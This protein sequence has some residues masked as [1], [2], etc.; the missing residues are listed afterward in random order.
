M[1]QVVFLSLFLGLVT[2][3]QT[4]ALRVDPAVKSVRIELGGREAGKLNGE[5]WT[6]KVDFGKELVPRELVA[7]GYDAK[8][9][10]IARASQLTNLS[11]PP[12]Q[13]DIVVHRPPEQ[14]IEVELVGRHRIHKR[15]DD[16]KLLLDG[17]EIKV[18]RTF[19]ARLPALESKHTHVLSAEVRFEDGLIARRD[20]VLEGE[21]SRSTG[22][23][24]SGVLVTLAGKEPASLEGCFSSNGAPLRASGIE[25]TD[26]LVIMVKDPESRDLLAR[27]LIDGNRPELR[28]DAETTER[29][30]WPVARPFN[31][32]GEPVAIA[33]PQ[34]NDRGATQIATSRGVATISWLLTLGL[35]PRPDANEPRQYADAVAVAGMSARERGQ[36]RAV[37]LLLGKKAD[38]SLYSARVVRRYLEQTGVPL[39]IW[40]PDGPRPDLA[41][42][43]GDV[44][45]VSSAQGLAAATTR[46]NQLLARQRIV[47]LAA[48]PLTALHAQASERCGL[49]PV[50]HPASTESL[51]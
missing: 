19:R 29:M 18:G 12:A 32:P 3:I 9:V 17:K 36:R 42:S 48:D 23:E 47:W 30:L 11:P 16:A 1:P 21:F 6:L 8:G 10:E 14:P 46:L 31:A 4:V 34:S 27:L 22:F 20:V 43:W 33:F 7:I 39:L 45:D 13:L 25:K 15:V 49:N 50:A 38:Q 24:L 35:S 28:L 44:E 26:A 2:G 51:R 37:V 41:A 5:P 40:S